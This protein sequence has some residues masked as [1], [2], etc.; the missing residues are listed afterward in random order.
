MLNTILTKCEDGH[1]QSS[2]LEAGAEESDVQ[3]YLLLHSEF[4]GNM[5]STVP[6]LKHKSYKNE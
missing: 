1:L 6:S 5:G 3:V 4:Q 2:I